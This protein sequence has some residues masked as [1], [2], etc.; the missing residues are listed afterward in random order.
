MVDDQKSNCSVRPRAI[1]E[2]RGE[3]MFDW[4]SEAHPARIA[5]FHNLMI[6]LGWT[7]SLFRLQNV[8]VRSMVAWV[9]GR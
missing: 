6:E 9:Y 5:I 4:I 3:K 2:S 8:S 1:G 7:G